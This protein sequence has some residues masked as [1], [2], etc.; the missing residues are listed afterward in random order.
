MAG[1]RQQSP[2]ATPFQSSE[3][4]LPWWDCFGHGELQVV[5]VRH[6]HRL[7]ALVPL[8]LERAGDARRATLLGTGNSDHLDVLVALNAPPEALPR[9]IAAAAGTLTA[10]DHFEFE[11]LRS[12]S[13]V[14]VSP[15]PPAAMSAMN[16]VHVPFGFK[17]W[18]ELKETRLAESKLDGLEFGLM[19]L[20]SACHVPVNWPLPLKEGLFRP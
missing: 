12:C 16:N 8:L 19:F 3:W 17:F 13:P 10:A 6:E 11:S 4:L 20:P 2:S 15:A 5:A 1:C 14:L 18:Y 9:A 7:A